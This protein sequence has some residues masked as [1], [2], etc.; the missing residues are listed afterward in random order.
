MYKYEN[1]ERLINENRIDKSKKH[2][3]DREMT[4]WASNA[5]M[6]SSNEKQVDLNTNLVRIE[7]QR[8]KS[9]LQIK[10]IG[11]LLL[12]YIGIFY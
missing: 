4:Q 8:D 3:E 7:L 9:L 10:N 6:N 12:S 5:L 1:D 2:I 11:I